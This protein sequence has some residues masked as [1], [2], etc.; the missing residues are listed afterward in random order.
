MFYFQQLLEKGLAGIDA[1]GMIPTITGISYAILLVS[2]LLGFY[3]AAMRGGDLQGL[4]VSAIK[5]VAV[6]IVLANWSAIFQEVNA[7]FN[8]VAQFISQASGA[9]DM[10]FSWMDQLRAQFSDNGASA[11]LPAISGTMAAITSALLT[12]AAYLIYAAMVVIFA[13]FYVL[14]GCLLY[15][16]GP[17][18]LAWLPI[19]GIG[20][21]GK[22]YAVNLMVWNAWG[23]LYAT[24][25]SLITAIEFNRVE[26][27][28]NGGFLGAFFP[29]TADSAVL[30][31]VSVFYALALGLI[32]F[33]AKRLIT[34]DVGASAYALVRAG[35]AA[36]GA[37]RSAAAG[38]E[39]GAG[40]AAGQASSSASGLI[41]SSGGTLSTSASMSS[42]LPPPQPSL[43]ESI[44]AGVRS[45][46]SD[47]TAPP[48]PRLAA[49]GVTG[50]PA[51]APAATPAAVRPP[52]SSFRPAG[53][54]ETLAFHAGRLAG[55]A[56]RGG[57]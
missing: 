45:A 6:A 13:F 25:G 11:L 47:A 56:T 32:P 23:V 43:A 3:Q 2:F 17:L 21:L 7:S 36:A 37:M 8:Q 57:G 46:M 9:G 50:P 44:R 14:Y 26:Q 38:F 20:Q 12:L 16:T 52:R 55:S 22:S 10:F 51:G 18:V 28:M 1:T 33:I 27:I 29:G 24:F 35:A 39:A 30:G 40:E 15:V 49:E 31:L 41:A 48:A 5:Y 53:V 42:S 4:V 19:A 34:G 54:T